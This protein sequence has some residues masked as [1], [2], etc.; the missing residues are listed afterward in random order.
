[1]GFF[2]LTDKVAIITGASRGIGFGIAKGL[3]E[4]GASVV[5]ADRLVAEGEK[6]VE[7]LRKEG[8]DAMAVPVDVTSISA[9]AE[10]VSKVLADFGT[11]DI[12]VNNAAVVTR[13]SAQ[14]HTEED[15]DE[16]MN[17]NL[18]GLFFCCQLVSR[19]MI[20][21]KKGSIINVS[22]NVVRRVVPGRCAYATS[23]AGVTY[24]T[25]VLAIEWGKHNVRV[26]AIAPGF[27]ITEMTKKYF[28]EHPDEL[29]RILDATPLGGHAYPETYV[30]AAVFLASDA[31]NFITGQTLWVDG[32]LTI[33]GD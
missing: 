17:T 2:D 4:S 11:I 23:K 29:R 1:M 27:T 5:I 26:N 28:D 31:S 21:R 13:K 15:W 18:K 8:L 3:A 12:L 19:H 20:E 9:I 16:N 10:L 24:L 32:G 25:R 30:G 14:D 6:A 7:S 22:S 33:S